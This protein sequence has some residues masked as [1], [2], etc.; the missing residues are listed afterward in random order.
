[1]DK[2][3]IIIGGGIA[4]LLAAIQLQTK[5]IPC[6]VIEK[7]RYPFHRVCGEYISNEAKPF[8]RNLNIYPEE[9]NPPFI[10]KLQLSSS[11]GASTLM[12]LDLGGFGISRFAFDHFL[13]QSATEVGVQFLFEEVSEV[14]F[15]ENQFRVT[16]RDKELLADI[17]ICAHGKRS[18]LDIKLQR[19]F[20]TK[21]S[22][23]VGVKYHIKTDH[24]TDVI[25]LHNFTGGYC[26]ISNVETGVT[27]LCYLASSKELKKNGTI[28]A[29]EKNVLFKNPLLKSIFLNSEFLFEKPEVISEISFA[30]KTPIEDHMIMIGDAAGMITPLC[31]NGMAMAIHSS[32]IA[33]EWTVKFLH[34]KID[35]EKLERGYA[36]EW[37]FQ[38]KSRLQTG[39]WVQQLLFGTPFASEISTRLISKVAPLRNFIIQQT[40]GNTF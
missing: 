34:N 33:C 14:S 5:D 2:K 9:F 19:K 37:G 1:M 8:L 18:L 3:V 20:I 36:N 4:G 10:S 7:K 11:S 24:P 23:F 21:R 27:N 13:F 40:H 16:V 30:T 15:T 29:L 12:P 28:E 22:P 25:G 26:G 31:G 35:R 39:R 6:L 38:F 32:K 17:V